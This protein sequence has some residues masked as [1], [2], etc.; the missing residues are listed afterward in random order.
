M[1]A[2]GP[3]GGRRR[4][5]PPTTRDA[6]LRVAAEHVALCPGQVFQGTGTLTAYTDLLVDSHQRMFW[7]D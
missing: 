5:A 1:G 2:A 7:S 3:G 4:G 6:A